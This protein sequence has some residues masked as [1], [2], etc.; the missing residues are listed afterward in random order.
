MPKVSTDAGATS[1]TC[2]SFEPKLY[3]PSAPQCSPRFTVPRAPILKPFLN[4]VPNR[5]GPI[6]KLLDP[7]NS[8][9]PPKNVIRGLKSCAKPHA[10]SHMT[11][12]SARIPK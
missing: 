1:V 3:V 10:E 6:T 4:W 5:L 11:R 7:L 8:E 9:A 2:K 12:Q